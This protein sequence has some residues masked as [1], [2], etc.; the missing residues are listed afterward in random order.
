M[1][2][3]IHKMFPFRHK[4]EEMICPY[5]DKT[6]EEI[7]EYVDMANEYNTNPFNVVIQHEGTYCRYT[8]CFTCTTCYMNIGAPGIDK[9]LHAYP[10]YRMEVN[11]I[12]GQNN[13]ELVKY[14]LG[15]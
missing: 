9:L 8:G 7:K 13:D 5:C 12:R 6:P 10:Y 4:V 3:N 14:R 11:P 2:E 15:L 1:V